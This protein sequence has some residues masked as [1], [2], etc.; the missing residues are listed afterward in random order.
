MRSIVS[1]PAYEVQAEHDLEDFFFLSSARSSQSRLFHEHPFSCCGRRAIYLFFHLCNSV[2]WLLVHLVFVK[3]FLLFPSTGFL[4]TPKHFCSPLVALLWF[5]YKSP[6]TTHFPFRASSSPVL[7]PIVVTSSSFGPL[8]RGRPL[9]SGRHP[10]FSIRSFF[11]RL[12]AMPPPSSCNSSKCSVAR[13]K[14]FSSLFQL[15]CVLLMTDD[16]K[17][18]SAPKPTRCNLGIVNPSLPNF[19]TGPHTPPELQ[20]FCLPKRD[21]PHA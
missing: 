15:T 10:F 1:S 20:V 4:Q 19:G 3:A 11:I 17:L 16:L 18:S 2:V 6:S 21:A 13:S 14:S 5:S 8:L 7:S 12:C 9:P